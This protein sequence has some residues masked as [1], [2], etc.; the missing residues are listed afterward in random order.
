M[1]WLFQFVRLEGATGDAAVG[2]LQGSPP[3]PGLVAIVCVF[4]FVQTLSSKQVCRLCVVVI[5][6]F[7]LRNNARKILNFEN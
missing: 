5:Y 1:N 7:S 2:V 6:G 4:S 3:Y